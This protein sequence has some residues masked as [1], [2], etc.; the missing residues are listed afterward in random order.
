MDTHIVGS[1]VKG[2]GAVPC[3]RALRTLFGIAT[4]L[5]T[6]T[7][8]A[9]SDGDTVTIGS[10]VYTF[11]TALTPTEGQVLIGAS[12]AAALDNIKSAVNGTAGNGTTYSAAAA[13]PDVTA[14]TNT[15]TT[16]LFQAIAKGTAGNS[17]ATTDS[18]NQLSW[19]AATLTGGIRDA[20]TAGDRILLKTIG[21]SVSTPLLV[22]LLSVQKTA[23]DG[24][25]PVVSI[26]STNLA[27]G[28]ATTDFVIGDIVA[29]QAFKTFLIYADRIYSVLYT[30]A[31]GSPTVGE[32]WSFAKVAGIGTTS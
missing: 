15:N 1:S 30:V 29:N 2:F 31:T 14:T 24:T 28:D 11:K 19:G 17:I 32:I 26:H 6:S 8:T 13:N 10:K 12:A 3:Q 20:N 9:P 27:G 4:G 25:S 21:A 16:Q 23:F 5:L 7:G 18:G 22:Q